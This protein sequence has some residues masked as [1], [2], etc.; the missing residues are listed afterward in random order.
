MKLADVLA[1][2]GSKRLAVIATVDGAGRPEA[3]LIGYAFDPGFG[4]VFDTSG[5]SR[6]ACNLR[7]RAEAAAV[8]GWDDETTVQLEGTAREPVGQELGRAKQVYFAIWPDGRARE[9]WQDIAYFV[10]EPNWIRYSRYADP[11]E[12]V[13]FP[14]PFT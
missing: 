12:I 8:I 5:L 14:A 6:K 9:A 10:I 11:P 13:E 4:L 1:F 3:A 7:A 2:I